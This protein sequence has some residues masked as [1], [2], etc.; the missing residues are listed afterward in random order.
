MMQEGQPSSPGRVAKTNVLPAGSD[1]IPLPSNQCEDT[2]HLSSTSQN[3]TLLLDHTTAKKREVLNKHYGHSQSSPSS[4]KDVVHELP[5][6]EKIIR[7]GSEDCEDKF[8]LSAHNA[9]PLLTE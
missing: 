7:L 6:G 1:A 3:A 9:V 8:H 5:K 4:G 2:F